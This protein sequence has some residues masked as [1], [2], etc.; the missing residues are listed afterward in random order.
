MAGLAAGAAKDE[1]RLRVELEAAAALPV[2]MA[3]LLAAK[4]SLVFCEQR[5]NRARVRPQAGL[6]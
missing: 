4:T 1:R 5:L 6:K 3:G 2:D